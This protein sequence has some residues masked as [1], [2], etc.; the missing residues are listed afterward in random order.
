M[1]ATR[2]HPNCV[3]GHV[4]QVPT[5]RECIEDGCHGPAGTWWGPLW[6]PEHDRERLD[7]INASLAALVREAGD[8]D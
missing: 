8:V 3:S 7:R 5:G 1:T 4:C 2:S 6:C